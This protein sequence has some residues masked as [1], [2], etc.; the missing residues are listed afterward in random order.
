MQ[1]ELDAAKTLNQQLEKDNEK[2]EKR[3]KKMTSQLD[4][5][6]K[7]I[8]AIEANNCKLEEKICNLQNELQV[9]YFFNDLFFVLISEFS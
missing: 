4:K 3:I 2:Q 6:N 9:I 7:K 5:Y 1:T 8:E